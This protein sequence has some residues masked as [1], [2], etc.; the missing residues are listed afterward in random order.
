MLRNRAEDSKF[1]VQVFPQT[2]NRRYISA[3]IA[4][5]CRAPNRDDGAVF[6]V[7]FV[8]FIDQLVG[9]RYQLQAIDMIEL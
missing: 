6:E 2:H 9:T 7:I 4:V 3:S 1:R 8:A 5:V